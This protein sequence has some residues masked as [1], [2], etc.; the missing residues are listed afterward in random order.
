ME[1]VKWKIIRYKSKTLADKKNNPV[2]LRVNFA[3]KRVY[4]GPNNEPLGVRIE[5][6]YLHIPCKFL[7]CYSS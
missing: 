6:M 5:G 1:I 2:M 3:G 7:Y 4:W